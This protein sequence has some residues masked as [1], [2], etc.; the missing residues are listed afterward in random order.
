MD[1]PVIF[2]VDDDA[3]VRTAIR[4][5]LLSLHLPVRLFASA[6]DFLARTHRGVRGC[7]VLDLNLPG[8][9]GL[10]LQKQLL[11]EE[12]GLPVVVVTSHDSDGTRDAAL[13]MGAVSYL[14]KPFNTQQFLAS[15][16]AALG[17]GGRTGA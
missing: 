12:W 2:V 13:R 9:N 15:V 10:Q 5:S 1:R 14:E 6:E 7:L 8:M 16:H 11:S 4:R 17:G 3:S